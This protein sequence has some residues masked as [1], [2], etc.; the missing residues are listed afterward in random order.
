[1]RELR[2]ASFD[3]TSIAVTIWDDVYAPKAVLQICHGVSEHAGRY[4]RFAKYMNSRGYIVFAD[5]HRAHGKTEIKENLGRHKGDVFKD[6]LS[7]QIFFREWLKKEYNLPVFFLGHSYG[8]FI[9]QAL[10]QADTGVKAI[11][12]L[13]TGYMRGLCTLGAI[14]VAP[15]WLVARNWRPSIVNFVGNHGMSFKGDSGIGQWLTSDRERRQD[16]MDDPLCGTHMSVNFH[17][18]MLRATSRLY[19]KSA[20]SK[21]NP[22]TSIAIF[23][24][25]EDPVGMKQ[26]SVKKLYETYKKYGVNC[27]MHLYQDARHEILNDFCYEQ[28][29]QDIADYFDKYI[30]YSQTSIEDFI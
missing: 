16:Y 3:D 15:I 25:T 19:S 27:E 5:D 20:L 29:S 18:S 6:T 30:I 11:A 1:M 21:L 4:D 26:K 14:L 23:G 12:L 7:D 2:L 8:S 9:G 17:F 22:T 24:G 13:G 28:A 10:A